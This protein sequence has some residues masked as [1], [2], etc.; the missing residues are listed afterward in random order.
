MSEVPF[1]AHGYGAYFGLSSLDRYASVS[2]P[3]LFACLNVLPTHPRYHD[4]EAP[5]EEGLATLRRCL[6]EFAKQ[7][8]VTPEKYKI[9]VADNDGVRE[10]EI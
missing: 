4:P 6:D 2:S 7:V 1:A 8:V 9:K 3:T 5:L 10:V